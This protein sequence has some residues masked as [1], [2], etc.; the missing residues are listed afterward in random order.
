MI[1][2][3]PSGVQ[4]VTEGSMFYKRIC[5]ASVLNSVINAS[6]ADKGDDFI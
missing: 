2:V 4:S 6:E 3:S 1:V 5:V